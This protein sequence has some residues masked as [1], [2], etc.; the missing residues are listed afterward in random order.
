MKMNNI[1][2]KSVLILLL[3]V[4]SIIISCNKNSYRASNDEFLIKAI[5]S[6]SKGE[7]LYLYELNV[8]DKTLLDSECNKGET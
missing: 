4:S 5:F 2:Y 1:F 8:H 6:N 7:I 3:I